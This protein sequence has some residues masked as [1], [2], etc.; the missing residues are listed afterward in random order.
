MY[1]EELHD[2]A[3]RRFDLYG[4]MAVGRAHHAIDF[5][6]RADWNQHPEW[7]RGRR[8]EII[9]RIKRSCP[10]PDY[11]YSGEGVL[12]DSDA[13]RLIEMA[14]GLSPDECGW[15]GCQQRALRGKRLCVRHAYRD[16]W[17]SEQS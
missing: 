4:E 3:W 9:A 17:S 7:A 16:A 15:A 14:G 2:G 1:Y 10:M 12:D 8:D 5:G 6:S 13:E 11:D